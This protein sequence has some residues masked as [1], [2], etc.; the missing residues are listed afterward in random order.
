MSTPQGWYDDGR[1]NQ[2]WWDGVQ[3]TS[4]TATSS[5][6]PAQPSPIPQTTPAPKGGNRLALTLVVVGLAVVGLI[7]SVTI[8]VTNLTREPST[9]PVAEPSSTSQP[10]T[11][12]EEP[13]APSSTRMPVEE[14]A[15]KMREL[16]LS[17]GLGNGYEQMPDFYPCLSKFLYE[18]EMPDEL[19]ERTVNGAM[20]EDLTEEEKV[21]AGDALKDAVY[22]CDPDGKGA[23][24]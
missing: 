24:G 7:V 11:P 23:W 10:E 17:G 20:P 6:A 9:P 22:F 14:I 1:G 2:R 12:S 18:S 13:S 5:A 21:L 16:F 19:L 15:T 3:W 4:H 8:M